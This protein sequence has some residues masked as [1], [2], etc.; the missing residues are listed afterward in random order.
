MEKDEVNVITCMLLQVMTTHKHG[1]M[2]TC[3]CT[4]KTSSHHQAIFGNVDQ[5]LVI[6]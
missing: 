4:H 3:T 1:N 2:H 5:Q 6:G